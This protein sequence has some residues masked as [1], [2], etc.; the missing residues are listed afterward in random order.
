MKRK[1][2]ALLAAMC[3][4]LGLTGC[5]GNKIPELSDADLEAVGE[6][7]AV[8]LMKYDAGH[9][10]R[11]VDI[12]VLEAQEPQPDRQQEQQRTDNIQ[13]PDTVN[14]A[15]DFSAGGQTDNEVSLAEIMEL[16]DGI[17]PVFVDAAV[18]DSYP[19]GDS[20]Y[21]AVTATAGHKLL[22]CRFA[23]LNQTET[24]QEA[25]ILSTDCRFRVIVNGESG[26]YALTTMLEQDM[27]TFRD[28]IPAGASKEAV[29]IIETDL[30]DAEQISSLALKVKNGA[31]RCSVP[32]L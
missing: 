29:L 11:L 14:P 1:G 31:D 19:E 27:S 20:G 16:P 9:R 32:L 3:V 21:F 13:Q 18:C 12:S 22:V 15:Q 25:D 2:C 5:G 7:A 4:A 26:S 28:T 8:T 23:L 17:E 30:T 6:Y 10:S 24:D